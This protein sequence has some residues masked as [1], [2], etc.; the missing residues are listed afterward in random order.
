[1]NAQQRVRGRLVEGEGGW[2][3]TRGGGVGETRC[4]V[5]GEGRGS[6]R[7]RVGRVRQREGKRG[8]Q[9]DG[10]GAWGWGDGG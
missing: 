7:G 10:V 4:G 1:M 2:E 6:V 9:G 3:G 5:N 8:G